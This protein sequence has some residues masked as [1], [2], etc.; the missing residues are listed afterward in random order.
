M[1]N[2]L[3]MCLDTPSVSFTTHIYVL[4][5]VTIWSIFDFQNSQLYRYNM[6]KNH[7]GIFIHHKISTHAYH[8][9]DLNW[10]RCEGSCQNE[11]RESHIICF[12]FLHTRRIPGLQRVAV[13]I[14]MTVIHERWQTQSP[15]C[16]TCFP[17]VA[18]YLALLVLRCVTNWQVNIWTSKVNCGHS[19]KKNSKWDAPHKKWK[20]GLR[21]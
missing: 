19:Q 18:A 15:P 5:W 13:K 6:Q 11:N 4:V 16:D 10:V 17:N 2:W 21:K 20:T 8:N 7:R 1:I 3:S 14:Q 12:F 9:Q